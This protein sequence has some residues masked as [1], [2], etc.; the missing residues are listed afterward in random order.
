MSKRLTIQDA[1]KLAKE[2]GGTCLST[3]Y[4]NNRTKM[5]WKCRDGHEWK[6]RFDNIKFSDNWCPD[7][8]G[9]RKKNLDYCNKIAKNN[10]GIC[11]SKEYINSCSKMTWKCKEGHIWKAIAN[12]VYRGKWCPKCGHEKTAN[13]IRKTIEDMRKL[14]KKSG[15]KCIST[16]Y[17]GSEV[18]LEW[19]CAEK[20]KWNA[21]PVNITNGTWCPY[22]SKF[23]SENVCRKYFESMFNEAFPKVKPNWLRNPKTGNLLELDGYC[24]KLNIA[25]EHQGEQHYTQGRMFSKTKKELRDIK[26]RDRLK[27]KL[28]GENGI[29]LIEIPSLGIRTKKH[30][31]KSFILKELLKHGIVP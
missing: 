31:L 23:K 6:S 5:I 25:F 2:R 19:E 1:H 27:R 22:C 30:N 16:T 3:T 8:S 21:R 18:S 17:R 29:A 14:A 7:C 9:N 20:H 4:K 26:S 28:C 11:L 10:D 15:G 12:N 13:S 24:E